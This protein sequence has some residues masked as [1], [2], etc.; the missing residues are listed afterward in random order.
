[1]T[2]H[3]S[4]SANARPAGAACDVVSSQL[5]AYLAGTLSPEES[6]RLE[7]HAASCEVCEQELDAA[8]TRPV[9]FSPAL[10]PS[11]RGSTLDAV[12]THRR[13]AAWYTRWRT[14]EGIGLGLAAAAVLVIAVSV[15]DRGAAGG[16]RP[17]GA[18]TTVHA[19]EAGEQNFSHEVVLMAGAQAATEFSALDAAL[20][21]L[22]VALTVTPDDADL[23]RF[24]STIRTRR[25]ELEQRVR[26][27]AL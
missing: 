7:W 18:E 11:L 24:R 3:T 16:D 9:A 15:R 10:P 21:E 13:G 5:Q 26:N 6:A 23:R 1:M 17:A 25:D 2:Q 12:Q 4:H 27:A 8:S 19:P 14:R 20:A 22:E